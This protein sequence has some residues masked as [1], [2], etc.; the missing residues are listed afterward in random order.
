MVTNWSGYLL[1]G[2]IVFI[3]RFVTLPPG[4]EIGAIGL[5]L[6]GGGMLLLVAA[7][8]LLCARSHGRTWTFRGT[9]FSLPSL[10]MAVGQVVASSLNRS[11][12]RRV[13]K[14]CVSTCRS[15]WSP[16]N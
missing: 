12:E 9:E 16:D 6:T 14:E 4:W 11:A 13:G 7:Y 10:R 1:L 15:R 3:G 8:L 2:G 5:Q